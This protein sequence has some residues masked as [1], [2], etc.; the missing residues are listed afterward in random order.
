MRSKRE[1]EDL[2]AERYECRTDERIMGDYEGVAD[3]VRN[4]DDRV[5]LQEAFLFSRGDEQVREK[6]RKE[7]EKEH[8][9]NYPH[10][11][12]CVVTGRT[13]NEVIGVRYERHDGFRGNREEQRGAGSEKKQKRIG[14]LDERNQDFRTFFDSFRKEREHRIEKNR[15]EHHSNFHDL[16]RNPVQRDIGIRHVSRLQNR[17]QNDVDLKKHGV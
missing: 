14:L 15:S 11:V 5:D 16:H 13:G 9:R 3:K 10:R 4:R 8:E 1:K 12:R 7:E 6:R 2:R 17:K